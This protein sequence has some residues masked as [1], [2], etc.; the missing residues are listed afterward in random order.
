MTAA[1]GV[2]LLILESTAPGPGLA[3]A[4]PVVVI[5][6]VSRPARRDFSDALVSRLR[7]PDGFNVSVFAKDLGHPRM[8][9]VGA[10]GTV[11]VTRWETDD[12]VALSDKGGSVRPPRVVAA[13]LPL[14]HGISLD[15]GRVYLA[16]PTTVWAADLKSDGSF[17]TPQTIIRDLPDA[18]QH[19]ART[20]AVG[21]DRA[22]YVSVGSSC[23]DCVEG[24]KEH[25]TML[26]GMLD[27]ST[28]TVFARGLRHTVGF[29]WH[30]RTRE[31]WGADNGSDWKG[32]DLP[33]E[34]LNRIVE[35]G[36]YGWPICYG[37]KV[38]DQ[39]TVAEPKDIVGREIS[40]EEYCAGTKPPALTF[41]AHSAPLG[42]VFYTGTQFPSEFRDDAFVAL[43][44]SWNRQA[45]IGYKVVRVHFENGQPKSADDFVTGFLIENGKALFGRPAGVAVG[46][47]G[48]LLVSDDTNG[49]IYRVSY[50]KRAST[51][52]NQ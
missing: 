24:N 34:E 52:L 37:A 13:N 30:P 27:G 17:E 5:G 43:H 16:S 49:V 32:D 44:G 22:L 50:E 29:A 12:V 19:R 15:E 4:P 35:G 9:A 31:L 28:R 51:S 39:V 36:V 23:N 18:G 7:V 46:L 2:L 25:A 41:D 11:Y 48:S 38:P 26:R 45:P 6:A 20:I 21:P 33:P 47:D 8:I 40:K 14:V 42:M 3:Q 1:A 10:D